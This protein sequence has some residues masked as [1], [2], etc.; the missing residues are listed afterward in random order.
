MIKSSSGSSIGAIM[1]LGGGDSLTPDDA[2]SA[3]ING[4]ICYWYTEDNGIIVE[5]M[6]GILCGCDASLNKEASYTTLSAIIDSYGDTYSQ[7]G[8]IHT[9]TLNDGDFVFV[10]AIEK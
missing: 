7:N 4:M 5:I 9:V 2:D 1:Y 3:E 8:I 6:G 10:L